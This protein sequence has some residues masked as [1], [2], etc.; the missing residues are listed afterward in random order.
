MG[1]A[2]SNSDGTS[3]GSALDAIGYHGT[4]VI[5][6]ADQYL[7]VYIEQGAELER[8]KYPIALVASSW[9]AKKIRCEFKGIP[10]HTGPTPMAERRNTLLAAS[11]V[12]VKV[13]ELANKLKTTMFSSVGLIEVQ[14]NS[15][16]TIADYVQLWIE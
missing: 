5:P 12:I 6:K 2:F 7:E 1:V 11:H 10:D 15:P 3:L 14:P 16:N 8:A 9:G 4:D 13:E